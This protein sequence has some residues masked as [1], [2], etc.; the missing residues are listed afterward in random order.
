MSKMKNPS[1]NI[2]KPTCPRC[3][4]SSNIMSERR[5]DGYSR[6][7]DCAYKGKSEEFLIVR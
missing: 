1:I 7:M 2:T 6:C 4:G 3:G 5:P